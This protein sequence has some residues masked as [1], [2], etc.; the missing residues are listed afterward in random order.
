LGMVRQGWSEGVSEG[1][2]LHNDK[3]LI[4]R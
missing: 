1:D 3:D 4:E 2:N